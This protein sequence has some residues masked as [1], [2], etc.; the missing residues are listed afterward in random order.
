MGVRFC[1][2]FVGDFLLGIF[3]AFWWII[4]GIFGIPLGVFV[5]QFTTFTEVFGMEVFGT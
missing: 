5:T 1:R 4:L 2:V 3:G